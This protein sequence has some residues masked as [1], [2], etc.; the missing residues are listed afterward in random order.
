MTSDLEILKKLFN[1][2][3]PFR[4]LPAGD[5]KYVDCREVRG[6]GDI[7]EELGREIIFSERLTCQLYSGH[8]GAGKS[9]ELLRLQQDLDNQ[10]YFVIYF[11]ADEEDIDPEDAQ[12]TDILLACTRHL[13]DGL[14]NNAD[15][16][17]LLNWLKDRWHDLQDLALTEVSLESLSVEVQLQQFAKLT[18][19]LRA[20]PSVRQKVRERINPYTI[21]LIDALNE[22]IREAK[23]K[24][25]EKYSLLLIIAD[26]LDRIVPVIQEDGRSNHDH[27]FL[28]RHE[29]LKALDCHLVYTVPISMLYSQKAAD[30]RTNYGDNRVLP[31]IMVQTPKNIIHQPGLNKLKEVIAKRVNQVI[32]DRALETEIFD[33]PQTLEQICLM[34]GGHV[35]ELLLLLR[36]AI[37][38]TDKLPI[39]VKAVQR[40]ITEA[41]DTYRHTVQENQWQ[42]LAN[43]SHSKRIL[44]DELHRSLLFN[45]CLL[46]YRYLD[47][48]EI[49]RWYDVHPLIKGIEEFKEACQQIS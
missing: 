19:N 28:D 13:L 29:Q 6:D 14:K 32:P 4:P 2:F 24:L 41:R 15:P 35:R 31:M 46:E 38:R 11:A 8:R 23:Q 42:A 47:G 33:S 37:K 12:Y 3:D 20:V 48:D 45:R 27:I 34:S 22:F 18:A 5:P 17:P 16:Q 36:A 10:G 1:S 9:T 30:L 7:L 25:P 39:S 49:K 44:N 43:V 26:N 40:A 21:T